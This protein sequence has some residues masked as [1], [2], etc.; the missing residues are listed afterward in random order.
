MTKKIILLLSVVVLLGSCASKF[1]IVK[2]KY[3]KGFYVS[4]NKGKH[5]EKKESTTRKNEAK[6]LDLKIEN[7]EEVVAKSIKSETSPT[8]LKPIINESLAQSS[9]SQ[10][11]SNVQ[12]TSAKVITASAKKE[13]A[14]QKKKEFKNI[15]AQLDNVKRSSKGDND[16][17][18]ILMI[19]LC[20]FWLI[21][22]IPVYLHDGKKI[23]MNFWITLLLNLTYIGAVIFSILVVLDVVN[24]A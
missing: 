17:N 7:T 18:K 20:L 6:H 1:S 2:R 15:V 13:A 10:S 4:T 19:I 12:T 24:L 22:L 16:T 14:P 8:S 21:N 3:N 5:V 11:K 23:T 9:I